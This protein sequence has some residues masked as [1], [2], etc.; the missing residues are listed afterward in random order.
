VSAIARNQANRTLGRP[1]DKGI[2]TNVNDPRVKAG[3][4][5]LKA[6]QEQL[7]DAR[8]RY[9]D[10]TS[11]TQKQAIREEVRDFEDAIRFTKNEV[12]EILQAPQQEFSPEMLDLIQRD[13]R[14]TAQGFTNPNEANYA[15][16]LREVFLDRIEQFYPT[17]RDL[18]RTYASGKM[19]QDA[20]DA[21]VKLST[22]LGAKTS[23]ALAD[24]ETMT[25]AQKNI[26]RDSFGMALRDK[27]VSTPRGQ[28]VA[29]QYSSQGFRDIIER[30][31]PKSDKKLYAEGQKLLDELNVERVTTKSKNDIL[32]GSRTEELR[33]DIDVVTTPAEAA[34]QAFTGNWWGIM[35]TLGKRLSQ[36]I[37]TEGAKQSMKI[38]S[39]TDPAKVPAILTRLAQEAR[40]A[41]ERQAYVAALNAYK[42]VGF[43]SAPA[44]GTVAATTRERED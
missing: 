26:F 23:D 30:L 39:E 1:A 36:Q 29:N 9:Q 21:G 17:F 4:Q 25:P 34:A 40:T 38:L 5:E 11:K 3:R 31:F 22:K 43:R 20:F 10:A 24:F 12:E 37:G 41:S 15:N 32:A 13:L 8:R 42:K 7:V 44:A 35:R 18:R 6:L 2:H 33:G 27:A 16:N 19:E 28:Q 14:L